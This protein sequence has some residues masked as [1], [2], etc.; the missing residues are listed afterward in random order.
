MKRILPRVISV[1]LCLSLCSPAQ[2]V[3]AGPPYPFYLPFVSVPS[4]LKIW[5]ASPAAKIQPTTARGSAGP[6]ALAGAKGAAESYQIVVSADV[7]LSGVNLTA[8]S[9]SDGA[10][11]TIPSANLVFFREAFIDYTGVVENE[12][13]SQPAP[14]SSPT[15]DPRVPDPLIPFIDP[16]TP[17][18]A[19]GAP[20]SVAA[21]LN[22]PVWLD[23]S[24]PTNAVAGNYGGT[25]TI[26]ATGMGSVALPISVTVWNFALPD[27]NIVT[28]YFGMHVDPQIPNYHSGIADCSGSSCWLNSSARARTIV[29]R[30]EELLHQHRA[31][32]WQN[33]VP[34]PGSGCTPPSDWSAYDAALQPYMDGSYWGNGVPSSLISMPFTPGAAWGLEASCSQAQYTALASAW[35]AH[36]KAKGWFNKA[37]VYAED[38]PP[39]E[40]LSR[41]AQQAQWLIAGDPGW[42][43]HIMDTTAPTLYSTAIL[44]PALGIYN[45]A[46]S[47]YDHW[48]HDNSLDPNDVA[49]GRSSWPSLFSQGIQLWFYESNAQSA[50]YPT[51]AANTLLGAE[52]Q[53]ML[54]GAWYEKASGFLLWD[55]TAWVANVPWGQNAGWGKSGD[56][57][58]LYPGNH[59]GLLAPA[60]SPSGVAIDGPIPSYRLKMVREGLQDWAL[61]KL[62]EQRG[63]GAYARAQVETVY[64]QL[65]GCQWQ[66]CPAL[67]NGQFFWKA[68][69]AMMQQARINIAQA[70]SQ[71]Y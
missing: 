46:L 39:P 62:A 69:G 28:T 35:A 6:I 44:N 59:D 25:L 40:D 24:I 19:V 12:P 23:V 13:G 64:G 63:L 61:F 18:R 55:T 45:V 51:F 10:G 38:E 17:G 4:P 1:F 32:T 11:H 16:Y 50:P 71:T 29:K 66:G 56:G 34:D 57:V 8:S 5:T 30:Y 31:S 53:I 37:L 3:K 43:A 58:L 14:K 65:G 36:L 21:G 7:A 9:L 67:V 49:Y 42:K 68:D 54:W 22:Q 41:I 15:H 20:F 27:M 33:F 70:I 2:P 60:G 52:P 26:S 48:A 47:G